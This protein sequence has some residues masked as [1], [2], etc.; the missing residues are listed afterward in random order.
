MIQHIGDHGYHFS[1]PHFA[2]LLQAFAV[3]GDLK[4]AFAILD[5]MRTYGIE[6][7]KETAFPIYHAIRG[8]ISAIDNAY[9]ALEELRGENK[10]VD[11]V[12]L[13]VIIHACAMA[14]DLNRAIATY[15]ESATLGVT[16]DVDTY[17]AV[18]EACIIAKKRDLGDVVVKEMKAAGISPNVATYA[19]MIAL[20]CTQTVYDDA[21]K[22]LEEMKG[23]GIVPPEGTYIG[24]I[25]RLA[26]ERDPR[27][28]VALEEM[29]LFGYKVE[30]GLREY[31][32]TGGLTV[33]YAPEVGDGYGGAM[34]DIKESPRSQMRKE[35]GNEEWRMTG[36]QRRVRGEERRIDTRDGQ[37]VGQERRV[38]NQTGWDVV[39]QYRERRFSGQPFV[40]APHTGKT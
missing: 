2:P 23:Y 33:Y 31:V 9:Y 15:R 5:I 18:L 4:N 3:K 13:N 17:N 24:L 35:N 27:V 39:G 7:E 32:S 16:P 22:F 19:K 10:T 14:G 30:E 26:K 36:Q 8:D 21:F 28:H 12:A 11:V 25:K 34:V 1:E 6:P 40:R 29:E 37:E 20:S 38:A